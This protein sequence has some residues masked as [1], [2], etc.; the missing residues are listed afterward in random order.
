MNIVA[1]AGRDDLA[2]VFLV[3]FEGGKIVECVE[4]VQ[5][6]RPREEKWVLMVSTLFG[7]PVRCQICDA[8]GSYAGRLT[9]EQ[10]HE[11]IDFLVRRRY[12]EGRI[13]CRQFKI[14]LAR[15]G[16]PVL[17]PAVLE[18]LRDLPGRYQA[19][20]LMPSLSTIAPAGREAFFEEL[21]E[22][23][24]RFYSGG[25]FQMQFS[26]HTTSIEVRR[27]LIP[28]PTWDFRQMAAYG[29]RFAGPGDRR[30]TLNFA[31]AEGVPLDPAVLRSWFDPASFMV[32]LTPVNPTCQARESGLAS[33]LDPACAA[34]PP[35]A[36]ELA[37]LG[38]EVVVSPG[39][40]E[41]SRIGSNCGQYLRRFQAAGR[42]V[43]DGYTYPL[44]GPVAL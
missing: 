2:R 5:P 33:V 44:G 17:N 21:L 6:P 36:A 26:L 29:E 38:Y 18:V 42:P 7:C 10:I 11:Q 37:G 31:L 13:P 27:R 22:I 41:E 15:M 1:T 3:E 40:Q 23:K 35:V 20:G 30:V 24:N 25:R 28:F 12:P 43:P 8:G 39:E 19:P 4:S 16:E 34:P 32:K 9:A 14:Q